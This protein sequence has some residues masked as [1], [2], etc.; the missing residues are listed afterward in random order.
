MTPKLEK[1]TMVAVPDTDLDVI[2]SIERNGHDDVL[3]GEMTDGSWVAYKFSLDA[4]RER[5]RAASTDGG[6]HHE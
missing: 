5:Q 4:W 2:A 6:N 3:G 1:I